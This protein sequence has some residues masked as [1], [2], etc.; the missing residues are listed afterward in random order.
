[1]RAQRVSRNHLIVRALRCVCRGRF[2]GGGGPASMGPTVSERK[3]VTKKLAMDHL[4]ASRVGRGQI[5]D[6]VCG[7]TGW[8]RSHARNALRRALVLREVKPRP[9][10]PP[11]YGEAVMKGLRF[12]W[13]VQGTPCVWLLA[14]IL[15]DLVPRLRRLKADRAIQWLKLFC[16]EPW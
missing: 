7:L 9:P 8:H 16:S 2:A 11:L 5:L 1:M 14:A 10:R 6:Q 12:L 4:R 15:L 3:A 13:A